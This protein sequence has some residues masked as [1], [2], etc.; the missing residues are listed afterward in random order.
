M[1]DGPVIYVHNIEKNFNKCQETK[2]F[3]SELILSVHAV[4]YWTP[5]YFAVNTI[6]P[7]IFDFQ[8]Y[9]NINPNTVLINGMQSIPT[10]PH[11]QTQ[12]K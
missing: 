11:P 3:T 5:I 4:F 2:P 10:P 1:A 7:R 8:I 6:G 9:I 12:P